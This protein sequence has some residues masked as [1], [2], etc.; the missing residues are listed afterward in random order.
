MSNINQ[1]KES[2]T[3]SSLKVDIAGRPLLRIRGLT[4]PVNPFL[5]P[6]TGTKVNFLGVSVYCQVCIDGGT[7]KAAAYCQSEGVYV[8]ELCKG[9]CHQLVHNWRNLWEPI[10]GK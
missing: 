10:G 2:N 5:Y 7:R 6:Y 9:F 4:V 1:S 8:C 3:T